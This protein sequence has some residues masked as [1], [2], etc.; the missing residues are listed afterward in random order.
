MA[1]Y[2]TVEHNPQILRLASSSNVLT[3]PADYSIDGGGGY[4]ESVGFAGIPFN[5]EIELLDDTNGATHE[6]AI[7]ICDEPTFTVPSDHPESPIDI[8]NK[9]TGNIVQLGLEARPGYFRFK[10]NA[11]APVEIRVY[12]LPN[13]N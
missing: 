3:E 2:P 5:A 4:T 6:V 12:R 11:T 1:I 9:L 8:A 7:E 10:N 13:R